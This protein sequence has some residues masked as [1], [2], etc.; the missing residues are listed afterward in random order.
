MKRILTVTFT[1]ALIFAITSI[2]FANATPRLL[3]ECN[4]VYWTSDDTTL[5]GV[6]GNQVSGFKLE[7]NGNADP[8]FWYYLNIKF[9]KPDLPAG[10]YMFWI[11]SPP[12]TDTAFWS[13]WTAIGVTVSATYPSWQW[14]MWRI[15]H[16][17]YVPGYGVTQFPMFG[18]VSDGAGNY[19]LRDGLVHFAS[20]FT[21][22]SPL[23]LNGDYPHGTYTFTCQGATEISKNA[24]GGYNPL[25]KNILD[26]VEMLI[27]IR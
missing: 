25:P 15:I 21:Q 10:V 27:T 12:S 9:I 11:T 4:M 22:E 23:R 16:G 26:G 19:E 5:Y 6:P 24:Q 14:F 17:G 7:L 18:L 8:N 20:G 1:F 2:G 13:Y 3:K